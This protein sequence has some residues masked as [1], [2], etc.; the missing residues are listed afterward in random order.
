MK[1]HGF[2]RANKPRYGLFRRHYYTQISPKRK[3]K[4]RRT[5][6]VR[7]KNKDAWQDC[8]PFFEYRLHPLPLQPAQKRLPHGTQGGL[9]SAA[10]FPT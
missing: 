5:E 10:W 3:E 7:R 4:K 8:T 6:T 2:R 1:L 9:L